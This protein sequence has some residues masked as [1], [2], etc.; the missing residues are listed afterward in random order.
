M[1]LKGFIMFK[2]CSH[3]FHYGDKVLYKEPYIN[4]QTQQYIYISEKRFNTEP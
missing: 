1:G 3:A 2:T 4:D